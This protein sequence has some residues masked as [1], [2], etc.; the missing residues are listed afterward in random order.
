MCMV[1]PGGRLV[2]DI[3]L[4][5]LVA[6]TILSNPARGMDVCLVFVC[7]VVVCT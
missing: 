3:G 7:C 1:V 4:G 6:G 2:Y 5:S